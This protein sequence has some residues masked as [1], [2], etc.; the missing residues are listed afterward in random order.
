MRGAKRLTL[1]IGVTAV[2]LAIA[3]AATLADAKRPEKPSHPYPPAGIFIQLSE[4]FYRDMGAHDDNT[5]TLSTNMSET[6]LRQ[7]AV[8][9]RYTVETNLKI[10][11][12]QARIIE[13]LEAQQGTSNRTS[14]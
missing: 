6:Y 3:A 1:L 4:D 5:R 10:L 11:Q 8:A 12:Q 13:L 2:V 9:T 14:K 7:I